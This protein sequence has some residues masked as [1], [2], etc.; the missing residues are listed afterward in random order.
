MYLMPGSHVLPYKGIQ[1]T[2]GKGTFV[3]AGAQLIGDLIIGEEASIWFNTVIRG[4]C[5]FI[6]I[7]NRTNVQDG[8]VIHV[9][10]STAPTI[11]GDDVTVGH[12]AVIHGCT[13]GRGSLVGM[14]AILLDHCE[15]GEQS[16]VAAGALLAPGKKYPS[17][18]LIKGSPAQ[19]ARP[20]RD[21]ELEQLERSVRYYL[22]YKS[23]YMPAVTS[24]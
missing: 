12:G 16:F 22:E 9:T 23:H 6:R 18:S 3:A 11:I 13:V 15:V 4:D 2:I 19:V 17:R 10:N 20:L 7:G 14:G 24:T 8:T 5:N 1:P 21:E